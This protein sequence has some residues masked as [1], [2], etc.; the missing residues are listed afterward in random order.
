[1]LLIVE[2]RIVGP[3]WYAPVDNW[4][5][6]QDGSAMQGSLVPQEGVPRVRGYVAQLAV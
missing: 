2:G 6:E 4:V 5:Q 1:M 3:L